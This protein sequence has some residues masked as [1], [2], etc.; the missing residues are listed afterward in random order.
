MPFSSDPITVFFF[1]LSHGGTKFDYTTTNANDPC[2][3]TYWG[4]T[5]NN[6]CKALSFLETMIFKNGH[7]KVFFSRCKQAS[8][9]FRKK[10]LQ[11]LGSTA[12]SYIYVLAIGQV[13][14]PFYSNA[15]TIFF[16]LKKIVEKCCPKTGIIFFQCRPEVYVPPIHSQSM[17]SIKPIEQPFRTL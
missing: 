6:I 9:L 12:V 8:S 17:V 10:I 14:D 5:K 13:L 1:V 15:T 4:K 16:S 7:F 11:K 2:L 3:E